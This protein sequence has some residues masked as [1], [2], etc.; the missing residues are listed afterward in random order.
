MSIKI[1]NG[2]DVDNGVL[3]TDTSN[4]RVGINTSSPQVP[5]EAKYTGTIDEIVR[6]VGTLCIQKL[7]QR[8]I[9][10]F[11]FP[12]HVPPVIC[13]FQQGAQIDFI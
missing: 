11:L 1:L 10:I 12:I 6:I 3:Y 5:L 4:N 9:M 8:V 7:L 2:I 13:F